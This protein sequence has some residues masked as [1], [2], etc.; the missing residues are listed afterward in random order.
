MKRKPRPS[1]GRG[2]VKRKAEER[3]YRPK[4]ADVYAQ[5]LVAKNMLD[6]INDPELALVKREMGI[7]EDLLWQFK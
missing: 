7:V 3:W 5:F 1:A 4:V 2:P 6:S